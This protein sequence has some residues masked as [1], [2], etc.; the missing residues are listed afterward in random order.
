MLNICLSFDYE[1]FLGKNFLS[2]DDTLFAPTNEIINILHSAG[3]SGTFF[4]DV[5]SVFQHEKFKKLDYSKKFTEQLQDMVRHEQ[6]VQLHI[7]T[8]WLL[9][10]PDGNNGNGWDISTDGYKIHDIEADSSGC[11]TMDSVIKRGKEYLCN[12]LIPVYPDYKCIAYRAGGFCV[13]PEGELFQVLLNNGIVIDSSVAP[14][15]KDKLYD[16]KNAPAMPGWSVAPEAGLDKVST[17]ADGCIYEVPI[18]TIRNNIFRFAKYPINTWHV[19]GNSG[20]GQCIKRDAGSK[21][22]FLI[23]MVKLIYRRSFG[24]GILSLDSRGYRILLEDL[25]GLY[26]KWECDKHDA[27]ICII[28]HP[29]LAS[30]HTL[31]NMEHFI[32]E[33]GKREEFFHFVTLRDVYNDVVGKAEK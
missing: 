26:R 8:N 10:S 16:F 17:D 2:A 1:L 15:L 4:A 23:N 32:M 25:Q 21:A 6:D 20:R 19:K 33:V 3:V 9:S 12:T 22:N 7:H 14:K 24:Y 5:C 30:G 28:C 13:Q 18:G 31:D 27:V 29:K 11:E